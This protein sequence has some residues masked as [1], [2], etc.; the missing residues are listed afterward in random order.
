MSGE[1]VVRSVTA[2]RDASLDRDAIEVRSVAIRIARA[3]AVWL[4]LL[5]GLSTAVRGAIAAGVPSPWI[6]PDEVV[7]SEVAK[8]I[9]AGEFPSVRGVHEL[10]WGVVYQ[11]LIAPAWAVF[12]DPVQ[13]HHAALVTNAF[14][15]SLAAVP[16]YFLARMFV[17]RGPSI[18]VAAMTVLVPSMAY[19]GVLMT[20]NAC[21]PAFL[22][23]VLLFARAVRTPTLANQALALVGLGIVALTRI[24]GMALVGA[25]LAAVVL[26]A[27]LGPRSECR[28]YLAR[29]IPTAIV[30]MVVSLGPM[31]ASV[32][33][34]DGPTAWLGSRSGTFD[35]VHL[36]EFPEWFVFLT[37]GLLLYVAVVPAAATAIV[38]GRGLS[39]DRGAPERLFAA[40]VLPTLLA[41]LVSV[42]FVSASLDVDGTENLN[43]RYVFYV[44]PLLFVGLALWIRERLPRPRPWAWLTVA[45]CCLTAALL[46]IDRLGYNANFQ[47][48]ALLPWLR[49]D[50][51]GPVMAACVTAFTL[52]CGALWLICRRDRVGYL[53]IVVALWMAAVGAITVISDGSSAS[54]SATAFSGRAADWV[55]R[56]V[57]A[58]TR[59]PVIWE[60]GNERRPLRV[61][62]WLMV[63]EFFNRSIG[64]VYRIGEPTYYEVFLPTVPVTSRPDGSI[65]ERRAGRIESPYVLATCLA[66]VEGKV[67]ARSP[68]GSLRV[69]A[70]H[71]PVRLSAARRC[72][73]D[74]P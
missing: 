2:P 74:T 44:V 70:T 55:D 67:L 11:A 24:Q 68:R 1:N 18:V 57:P 71:G 54:K 30:S 4:A 43:E 12:E 23:S 5:V 21:Y 38:V 3:P 35:E 58:G 39:R 27:C 19:T 36:S 63:T 56:S 73:P 17:G 42:S 32:A 10:G 47:S 45:A 6:L 31:L 51:S 13:A 37:A 60:Q 14:V 61:D 41:M 7:Y 40:V 8:S 72:E 9:A 64:D 22:L 52:A 53:W 69:V 62:F 34:G 48:V 49:L 26:Y 16:A 25:Y 46:P 15:M 33:L 50:V 59:V 28:A 65:V 66:P 29:F 20:E